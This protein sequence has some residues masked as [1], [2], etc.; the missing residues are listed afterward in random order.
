MAYNDVCLIFLNVNSGQE[1][2]TFAD[3]RVIL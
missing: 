3:F 1:E 2:L